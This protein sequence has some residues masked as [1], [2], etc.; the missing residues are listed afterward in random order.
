MLTR[1]LTRTALPHW[2]TRQSSH[3]ISLGV[4]HFSVR[5]PPDKLQRRLAVRTCDYKKAARPWTG[6]LTTLHSLSDGEVRP[7]QR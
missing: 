2:R 4:E 3:V 1:D 5:A 6:D 7:V